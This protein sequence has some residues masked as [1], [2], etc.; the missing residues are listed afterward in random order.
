MLYTCKSESRMQGVKDP[1]RVCDAGGTRG[2]CS[3]I[4]TFTV[5]M[6]AVPCVVEPLVNEG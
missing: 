5:N 2:R 1:R 4:I 6:C 3:H